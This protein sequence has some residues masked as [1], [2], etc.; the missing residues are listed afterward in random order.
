MSTISGERIAQIEARRDELQ[1]LMATGD[2]PSDRFVAVSKEYA[3]LEPVARAAGEVRRLRAE[4]NVLAVMENEADPEI[5]AMAREEIETIRETLP[6]AERGLALSLLPRDAADERAA[7]LEIRAGT[8]GDEAALFAGDLFR[9]Y[10]RYAESQ[11]WRVELISASSSESGGFKEAIA[12]VEGKG[13]FARLKFESG[14]HRVQRVPVTEAGGRIHTSAA[15]V[16]VLPEAEEVDV[17]IDDKDLRIDIYRSSGPGGQSVNTTDSAVRIVHIPTG[18]VV[19]QQDEKSQHKNKAKAMKV[20][21]TRLYELERDRLHTERAGARKS[22]VGSG[23]RSER[24]RTYNFPQG[25][26]TDHRI[27]LTLHR[28]PEILQ[29]ELDELIGALIAEDEA[30]RLASLDG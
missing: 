7:M 14:V 6:L 16:A 1:A 27:N 5:R 8:G 15:T 25:R 21:R 9:M 23:D 4:L 29:G 10:Q 24:I 17:K 18:L 19:I 11:G 12:S 26:V 28:L 2:L 30:E 13:V 20:L 22:M 3:E